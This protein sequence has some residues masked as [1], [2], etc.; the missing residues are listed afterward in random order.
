MLKNPAR[1]V[2]RFVLVEFGV[3]AVGTVGRVAPRFTRQASSASI[4]QGLDVHHPPAVPLQLASQAAIATITS[5]AMTKA[6]SVR[7][8]MRHMAGRPRLQGD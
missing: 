3:L 1:Q 7:S 5:T 4:E 2:T 8:V 6:S